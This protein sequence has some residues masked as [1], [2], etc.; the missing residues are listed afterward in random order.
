MKI[1]RKLPIKDE[2][3]NVI[4]E[5]TVEEFNDCYKGF[6]MAWVEAKQY[7]TYFDQEVEP[8]AE[9]EVQG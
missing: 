5:E 4:G 7:C 9:D 6:C 1:T 8:E 2:N 3:G